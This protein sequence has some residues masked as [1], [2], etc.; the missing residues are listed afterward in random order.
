M[1]LLNMKATCLKTAAN[2]G[3]VLHTLLDD[4]KYVSD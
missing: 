2:V 4:L 3:F 1:A